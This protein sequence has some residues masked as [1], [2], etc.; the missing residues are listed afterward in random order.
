MPGQRRE[1]GA[2]FAAYAYE[3]YAS[4]PSLIALVWSLIDVEGGGL[5]VLC[6]FIARFRDYPARLERVLALGSQRVGS[7][8]DS[9]RDDL[10][11]RPR[12]SK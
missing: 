8:R 3:T 10:S 2:R 11:R 5:R 6:A 1:G 7:L 12:A 4:F 9:S